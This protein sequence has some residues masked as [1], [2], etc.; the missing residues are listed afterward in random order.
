L[1]SEIRVFTRRPATPPAAALAELAE[2]ALPALADAPGVCVVAR[3]IRPVYEPVGRV[4]GPA[5][6]ARTAPGDFGAIPWAVDLLEA[7]DVLVVDAAGAT[8]RAVWG[9]FVSSRAAAVGCAG[10]VVDGA[11]RDVAGIRELKLA[12]FAAG[13]TPRGPR[14]EGPGEVNGPVTCG[15]VVVRPGDIVVADAEAIL[16]IALGELDMALAGARARTEVE[17]AMHTTVTRD[18]WSGYLERVAQIGPAPI[19]CDREYDAPESA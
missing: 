10:V 13:T 15:G 16:I 17:R 6:T 19:V 9:D 8:E 12:V 4:V 3:G 14:R 18:D 1:A 5:V 2:L 11:V 7:G